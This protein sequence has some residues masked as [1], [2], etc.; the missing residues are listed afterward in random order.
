MRRVLN[1][2]KL[3]T[4]SSVNTLSTLYIIRNQSRLAS[5]PLQIKNDKNNSLKIKKFPLKNNNINIRQINSN[6][7][8]DR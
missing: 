6:C 8:S 4:S 7:F 2:T 1:S 5:S 3:R